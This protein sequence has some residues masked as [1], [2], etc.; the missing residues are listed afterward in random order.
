MTERIGI[1][2]L[3]LIGG[4]TAELLMSE[5]YACAAVC[6]RSTAGFPERGG[7]LVESARELAAGSDILISALP[8]VASAREAFEGPDGVLAG[9]HDGLVIV[10]MN[11]FSLDDKLELAARVAPT[12]AQILDCPISGTQPTIRAGKAVI[13]MSGDEA[14]CDRVRPVLEI[15][16]PKTVYVGAYG[17]GIK[18]KLVIN[19]LVAA[20]TV[21]AAEG[22]L[23][24]ASMGLS[25]AQMIEVI[26][27]SFAGS[28]AF[29]L[30]A[31]IIARRE[32][33]PSAGPSKLLWK[34]L[35]IIER[36]A[37]ALGLSAPLLRA[38]NACYGK[39]AAAGRLEDDCAVVF[40]ILEAE[41]RGA[42]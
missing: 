12:P 37:D 25:M 39:I 5:G 30:R 17:S 23:L 18:L 7:R 31:D 21:A 29:D 26:G 41:T 34:D 24:G 6:R 2:G 27:P 11:T 4:V 16:A 1:L 19:F 33:Q 22:L 15:V 20:H 40:E 38:C 3:G 8:N 13:M 32:W 42:G 9:A 28:A 10:D 36:Q 14:A 35:D